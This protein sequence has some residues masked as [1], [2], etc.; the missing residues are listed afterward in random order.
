MIS[1]RVPAQDLRAERAVLGSCILNHD[2]WRAVM[3]LLSDED[4]YKPAHG[5]V[6]SALT[7][8]ERDGLVPDGSEVER[9]LTGAGKLEMAGGEEYLLGLTDVLPTMANTEALARRVRDLA[10]VRAMGRAAALVLEESYEVEN[11]ADYLARA[12]RS[13]ALAAAGRADDKYDLDQ[14]CGRGKRCIDSLELWLNRCE[15]RER[16]AAGA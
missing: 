4:F 7:A 16:V 9:L 2:C 3:G 8:C 6:W 14:Q 15:P 10:A 12:E 11:P 13:I 1:N 5:L